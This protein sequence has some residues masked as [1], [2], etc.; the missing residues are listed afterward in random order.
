M[1]LFRAEITQ[2][3]NDLNSFMSL[4]EIWFKNN[5]EFE[6]KVF[7]KHKLYLMEKN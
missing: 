7:E 5:K 4:N 6:T 1:N 2:Y 3:L